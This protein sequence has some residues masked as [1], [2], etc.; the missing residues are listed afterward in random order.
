MTELNLGE[1]LLDI[2]LLFAATYLLAGLLA[3]IR[4]PGI[5][6]AL[7]MAMSI[8]YTP[9]GA[10]LLS[11]EFSIPISFLSQLGVLFLLFFIGLQIDPQEMRNSS[12]DI[13]WLTV[14][15]TA[16][17]FLLGM[18]LMLGL[19]YGWMLAFVIGMTRMP[20]AEA[21]IVPILDEFDLIRS[22]VG[23]FIIGAGVLDDV[24]EVF[25]VAFVSVWIGG[26]NDLAQTGT[27]SILLGAVTFILLAWISYRWLIGW[28][29]N[30][31]PRRSSN[32]FFLSVTVLFTFGGLSEFVQLGMIIGA[33]SA[34]V[35]L[36]PTFNLLGNIGTQVTQTI[37]SLSY[38]FLGLM[39]FFWV[40]LNADITGIIKA[41]TLAILLYLVGTI[42]KLIGVFIMV[43]LKKINV[44]EAWII[45][46]GL[47]ARL[48]T[49]II[50]AKILL[51]AEL[52]NQYLFTALVSAASLTAVTVPILFAILVRKWG[53][54]LTTAMPATNNSEVL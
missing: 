3:K 20:T 52:I 48:T 42:G 38:G 31:L 9:L 18:A 39:F 47:D 30:W 37:Q 8:H 43:P 15:N 32:L 54:Q 45:G 49:E 13:I 40:G 23:T 5:L 29:A 12:R 1:L 22:R 44:R 16:I 17:P 14:L 33:I 25:L 26:H 6:A 28:L 51:D 7:L 27:T 4:I 41:P 10:R 36:R 35:L 19:G 24:I 50:V 21:V 34:G 11:P 2:A 46:I 53:T